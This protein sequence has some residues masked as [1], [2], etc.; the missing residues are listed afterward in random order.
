MSILLALVSLAEKWSALCGLEDEQRNN[1]QSQAKP[2]RAETNEQSG[3]S[4]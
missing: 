2:E 3:C 1:S 4:S